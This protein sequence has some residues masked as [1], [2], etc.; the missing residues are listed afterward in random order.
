MQEIPAMYTTITTI[1]ELSVISLTITPDT[2]QT[3]IAIPK[4][5]YTRTPLIVSNIFFHHCYRI[6]FRHL[7]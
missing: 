5:I 6:I 3:I 7:N 1:N 2:R 4:P